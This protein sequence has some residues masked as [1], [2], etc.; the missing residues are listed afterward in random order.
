MRDFALR[1]KGL[2]AAFG[3]DRGGAVAMLF[4]IACIPMLIAVGVAVDFVRLSDTRS[5][6]DAIA[7]AA[8]LEGAIAAK[9]YYTSTQNS[10]QAAATLSVNAI[11][12]GKAQAERMFAAQA[13]RLGEI[14]SPQG[15]ASLTIVDQAITSQLSY[16]ATLPFT[17]GRVV[18]IDSAQVANTAVA[19]SSLPQYLD[20]YIVLDN[21]ASMGVGAT[22]G[23]IDLMNRVVGC[24]FGCHVG[25]DSHYNDARAAGATMRIDVL[26]DSIT[27]M[28]AQADAIKTTPDL[29]RFSLFTFSNTLSSL[30]QRSSDYAAL[31]TA[32]SG[33]AP[34]TVEGNTN[35]HVSIGQQL[36]PLLPNSGSGKSASERKSH[37]IIVT[38][39]VEDCLSF[40]GG[41]AHCDPTY[42]DWFGNGPQGPEWKMQAFDPMLCNAIKNT[43]ATVSVLNVTYVAPPDLD[44]RFDYV[45]NSVIGREATTIGGCATSNR[46][47]YQA[48]SPD[49][50]KAAVNAI[51]GQ[52]VASVRLTQ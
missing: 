39:A 34:D 19:V 35:Y 42:V 41:S 4:G 23:D 36:P 30:S 26:R 24:A 31:R 1:L 50:I 21:S 33:I 15:A 14:Q 51:F 12:A 8:A 38:D 20:I 32:V 18:A 16:T 2:A 47:F 52:L 5:K 28:L 3:A 7:D 43:G 25:G 49:E 40:Q 46:N 48:N 10:G 9:A 13:G 22:A 11:A 17:F 29:F 37:V 6:L 44:A 27:A 45:R